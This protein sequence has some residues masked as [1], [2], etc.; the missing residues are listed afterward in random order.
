MK[1]HVI[2][3]IGVL[4]VFSVLLAGLFIWRSRMDAGDSANPPVQEGNVNDTLSDGK[5]DGSDSETMW[6][7]EHTQNIQ[8]ISGTENTLEKEE[9]D[10]PITMIFAGDVLFRS[11]FREHYPSEGIGCAISNDLL[12][13][14]VNADL[15]MVN[16]EFP[17][18]TRG[19]PMEGKQYT[20]RID[21]SYVTA[22]NDLGIDIV[23]LAN[24]HVLDYGKDALKDT[25]TTLDEAGIRYAGAG[26]S[27]ERA[28]ELQTFEING[29]TIGILA[30]SRV[31][32]VVEWNVEN[33]VPGVFT[34]YDGTA[35][36]E[37]IQKAK[38]C[39]DFVAVYVHW[40]VEYKEYPEEYQ[41]VL[42][43]QYIDSGADFVVGTHTHC[44]QGIEYYNGK[45]IFYGLGN[46]GFGAGIERT[47]AIH[48]TISPDGNV[49]CMLIPAKAVN[50]CTVRMEEEEGQMLYRYMEEISEGIAVDAQGAVSQK[51][52]L[53]NGS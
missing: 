42:A 50:G 52:Q 47:L 20:F 6:G 5:Q 28:E 25:F 21:P 3:T 7:T 2:V 4:L 40:G 37:A 39:C 18:S 33:E 9:T 49:E 34:T 8:E 13:S 35:L 14:F 15:A 41:R 31:I 10:M 22:L 29:K 11:Y 19:V 36:C 27:K 26:E 43:K 23:T 32:P 17:F 24:N 51:E 30:A 12:D 44:L 53:G 38:E 45:P 48:V 46:F 1:K 16:Q